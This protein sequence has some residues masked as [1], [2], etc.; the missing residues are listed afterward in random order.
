MKQ[1]LEEALA[2]KDAVYAALNNAK[3]ELNEKKAEYQEALNEYEKAKADADWEIFKA[4][5]EID[6]IENAKWY[7]FDRDDNVG[8]TD[9]ANNA[10]RMAAIAVIFPGFFLLIAALVCLTAMTRMVEENRGQIGVYKAL[11]Y[12]PGQIAFRYMFYV[13]TATLI[14]SLAGL[15]IGLKVFPTAVFN[16]YRIM[17]RLPSIIAP[18]RLN[19][20]VF[21]I[22]ASE[23]TTLTVT[24]LSCVSA[25]RE[26]PASLARVRLAR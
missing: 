2:G 16:A 19:D 10:D 1:Q 15:L 9:Y 7:A 5:R 3:K 11:G 4:Q 25:L 22:I 24:Y 18:Y 13:G 8:Y 17:Y 26:V 12:T 20:F 6:D 21:A 23:A 14:G